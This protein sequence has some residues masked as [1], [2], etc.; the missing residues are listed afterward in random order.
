LAKEIP[1]LNAIPDTSTR[2]QE[3]RDSKLSFLL[4]KSVT[5]ILSL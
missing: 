4:N 2:P 5:I 1:A 3:C